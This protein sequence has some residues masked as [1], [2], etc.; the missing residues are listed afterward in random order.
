MREKM[1]YVSITGLQLRSFWRLPRFWFLSAAAMKQA[2]ESDGIIRAQARR[3]DGVH[4]TLTVWTDE[5]AMR[6]F[7]V[8]GSHLRAMKAFRGIGSGRTLGFHDSGVPGWQEALARW[9]AE[10]KAV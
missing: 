2:R 4:H 7:L 1:F 8:S 6:R 10:S 3:V 5:A 9:R